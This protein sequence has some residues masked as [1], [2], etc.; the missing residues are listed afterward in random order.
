MA[1]LWKPV[2]NN[3]VNRIVLS[4]KTLI[5]IQQK[6]LIFIVFLKGEIYKLGV[7]ILASLTT[8]VQLQNF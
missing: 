3:D 6:Q 4:S 5:K 7:E 1:I 2:E 8:M